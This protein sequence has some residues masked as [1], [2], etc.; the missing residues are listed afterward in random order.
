MAKVIL[1]TTLTYR[2]YCLIPDDGKR[3]EILEGIHHMTPAPR[4]PHQDTSKGLFTILFVYF[5]KGRGGKVYYAPIDV[6]LTDKDVV[7]P[8]LVVVMQLTQISGRGIEGPPL[9]IVEIL[10]PSNIEY[11]RRVKAKRYAELGV[12]HYWI[13]DPD[14]RTLECYKN[15]GGRYVLCASGRDRET[16]THPDFPGLNITLSSVWPE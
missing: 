12:P 1:D 2:E 4:P 3:H 10:S 6:I 14:T 9:L 7:Q 11:D 13:A 15:E 16:V 5:E 8:D